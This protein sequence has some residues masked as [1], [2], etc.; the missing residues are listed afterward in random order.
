MNDDLIG[1]SK[2]CSNKDLKKKVMMSGKL[3]L[4]WIFLFQWGA[5]AIRLSPLSAES[6]PELCAPQVVLVTSTLSPPCV[7]K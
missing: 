4:S 1:V 5:N 6:F 2:H 3:S 7:P